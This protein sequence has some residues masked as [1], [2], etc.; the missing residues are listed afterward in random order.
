M[1]PLSL[2]C[3]YYFVF[4]RILNVTRELY[5]PFVLS[6]TLLWGFFS[7]TLIEG[8]DGLVGN[9]SLLSKIAIPVQVFALTGTLTN[10]LTF[11]F[12]L[13]VILAATLLMGGALSASLLL[14]PLQFGLLSLMA[15]GLALIFGMGFVYFR[16]MKQIV[17]IGLQ[18]WFYATPVLYT[19]EMIP[20]HLRHYLFLNPIGPLFVSMRQ[21]LLHGTWPTPVDTLHATLCTIAILLCA[22][23]LL[24]TVGRTIPEAL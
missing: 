19:D 15:Y 2:G 18:V 9:V 1:T 4:T 8:V 17:Q 6:G 23:T 5:L 22:G 24:R 10:V 11:L 21:T 3:I 14:F 16:D 20:P 13:P 7:S 12:G